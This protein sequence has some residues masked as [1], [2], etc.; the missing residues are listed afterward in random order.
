MKTEMP[1]FENKKDLFNYLIQNK[2][3]LI[4][5]KK[6]SVKHSEGFAYCGTFY[7]DKDE[8]VKA[9]NA[10]DVDGSNIDEI[11][12]RA[13]INTT[14]LM[15]NHHDVHLPGIWSKSLKENKTIKHLQEHEMRF[16]KVISDKNDLNAYAK[17]Y[18]WAKLGYEY[19]GKTQALVF[20]SVVKRDRNDFMFKQYA[21]GNHSVGMQYVRIELA[22]N[23]KDFKEEYEV[24]QTYYPEVVNQ[25][26][27]KSV[28]YF[29]AVKEA[30][31]IEGSAVP[32]GS[33]HATPTLDNNIKDAPEQSTHQTDKEPSKDTLS[34]DDFKNLLKSNL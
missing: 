11:K 3:L 6:M 19:E 17:T 13:I 22:V 29:W 23:D 7:N 28:G 4:A 24:W 34:I 5:E 31:V 14:N 20:D 16:D 30:K 26:F 33:N 25:S 8:T 15:D 18:T 21:G 10:V 1:Q 27:A 32:M 12:V 9:N 2:S